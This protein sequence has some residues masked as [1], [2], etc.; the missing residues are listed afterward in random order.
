[1]PC[2]KFFILLPRRVLSEA[3]AAFCLARGG[4]EGG[5]GQMEGI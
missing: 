4:A 1:M 5:I 2:T 3:F